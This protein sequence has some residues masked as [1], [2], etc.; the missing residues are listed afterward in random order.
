M[1]SELLLILTEIFPRFNPY[2]EDRVQTANKT[3]Y[4]S[5]SMD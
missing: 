2:I 1:T 3:E 4:F 5:I